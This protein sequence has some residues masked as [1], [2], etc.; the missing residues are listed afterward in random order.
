MDAVHI[1][2]S[3]ASQMEHQISPKIHISSTSREALNGRTAMPTD[4]SAMARFT[5][6]RLVT[7]RSRWSKK[8]ARTTRQLPSNTRT[9]IE[10]RMT[11][12]IM[13]PGCDQSTSSS[14]LVQLPT[15]VVAF[16]ATVS[17]ATTR[18]SL[19]TP[20]THPM[21]RITHPKLPTHPHPAR[22]L[23]PPLGGDS[24]LLL[25]SSP[26]PLRCGPLAMAGGN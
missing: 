1:H 11:N 17:V 4:R 13:R 3:T 10:P 8:T 21:I 12:E 6:N 25:C 26:G 14:G 23:P 9:F 20:V 18:W 22:P 15:S 24:P 2:T 7:V 16:I 19:I 5:M